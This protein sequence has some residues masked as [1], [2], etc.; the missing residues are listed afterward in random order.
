[1]APTVARDLRSPLSLEDPGGAAA[2]Q[3][4]LLAEY[5]LARHRLT[6]LFGISDPTAICYC[7]EAGLRGYDE[8]QALEGAAGSAGRTG[9]TSASR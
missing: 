7:A 2:Y 8:S 1:V 6:G 9:S 3:E 5:V 4:H